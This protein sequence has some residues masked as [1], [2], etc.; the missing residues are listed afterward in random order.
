M[1]LGWTYI[2][3]P[4]LLLSSSVAFFHFTQPWLAKLSLAVRSAKATAWQTS[5]LEK[6]DAALHLASCHLICWDK[7]NSFDLEIQGYLPILHLVLN[8]FSIK[9]ETK[10]E[11]WKGAFISEGRAK[12]MGGKTME[13]EVTDFVCKRCTENLFLCLCTYLVRQYIYLYLYLYYL[14]LYLYISTY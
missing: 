14:Y 6:Q 5:W 1:G 12:G 13:Q 9:K 4:H 8:L 3:P 11:Y 10:A 7:P 2:E